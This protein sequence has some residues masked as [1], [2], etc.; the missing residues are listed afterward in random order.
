M[1]VKLYMHFLLIGLCLT[2]LPAP[3]AYEIGYTSDTFTD[4]ARARRIPVQ[5]YYPAETDGQNVPVA[6]PDSTGFPV[7]SFGHGYQMHWSVYAN[8]WTGVVPAGYIIVLP[9]TAGELFPDHQEF[10]LD[11][12]YVIRALQRQGADSASIFNEKI[13]QTSAVM[14][15]SMG[16][17]A[18]VLTAASDSGIT[19]L[20][21]LAAAE[22]NPSAIQAAEAVDIPAL[23]FAGSHDCVTPPE[24]HQIP[25][26]SALASD[27]K[28]RI[29][30]TGG[31]HCQFAEYNLICSLGEL[32]CSSPDITRTQQHALIDQFLLPWLAAK[33]KN[34]GEAWYTFEHRLENEPG[35]TCEHTCRTV[36][37]IPEAPQTDSPSLFRCRNYPNPFN[38]QATIEYA[39]PREGT[40]TLT[41]FNSRGQRMWQQDLGTQTMGLHHLHW[42]GMDTHGQRLA[43][44][45]YIYQLCWNGRIQNGKLILLE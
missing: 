39:L 22:T 7:I 45:C 27:C 21:N 38:S 28:T 42:P 33:L 9:R 16:G 37:A 43:S 11:L 23:L 41:V 8:I 36:S 24:I 17:G 44:G 2:P 1:T 12:A 34:D 25:I 3:H 15:H 32:G 26:Y 14:G 35:I 10:A 6:E 30:L 4:S 31:S 40:V 18:S 20:V 5:I 19:A 29:T 13:A